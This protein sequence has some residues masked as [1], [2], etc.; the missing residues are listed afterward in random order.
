MREL[1]TP[2]EVAATMRELGAKRIGIDGTDG[3]GKSHLAR[4]V[5]EDLAIP[6][7][8]LD[9]F[10]QKEQGGFVQ[11]IKYDELRAKATEPAFVVEGV[12]LLEV[13]ARA[14]ITIDALVYV[15]RYHLG[16][17]SDERELDLDE[18]LEEFLNKERALLARI[19]GQPAEDN[20]G[21]GEEIIRYHYQHRPHAK[22]AVVYRRNDG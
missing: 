3:A 11:F 15:K 21:L 19:S 4:A 18:P 17:W 14:E 5:A 2:A 20:F 1:D 9:D 7:L 13:L 10:V 22:A 12:C 6:H 8:N 16:Y